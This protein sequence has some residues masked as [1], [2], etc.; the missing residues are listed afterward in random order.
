MEEAP[1]NGKELSYFA[2]ASGT[3][4]LLHG[5]TEQAR[6]PETELKVVLWVLALA[7]KTMTKLDT[8]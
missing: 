5:T 2:H 4:L 7:V 6:M 1:K 3:T 8:P